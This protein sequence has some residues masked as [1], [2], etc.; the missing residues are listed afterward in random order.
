MN[1]F[2]VY[3]GKHFGQSAFSHW[4]VS[5]LT[6]LKG[7]AIPWPAPRFGGHLLLGEIIL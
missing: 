6:L 2:I 5:P 1:I 7:N 3:F 4:P